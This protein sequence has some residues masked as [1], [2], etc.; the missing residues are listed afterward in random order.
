MLGGLAACSR[1]HHEPIAMSTEMHAQ[2]TSFTDERCEVRYADTQRPL[3][4]C[5][6]RDGRIRA[7]LILDAGGLRG[8]SYELNL[9]AAEARATLRRAV[10]GFIDE[11]LLEALCVDLDAG[12]P[13]S[14]WREGRDVRGSVQILPGMRRV[15]I[16][17]VY[18]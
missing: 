18:L 10:Q 14:D 16:R 7:W 1:G 5:V 6:S 11:G 12:T 17:W 3:E 9:T 8:I 2:L 15:D 13:V 4:Q